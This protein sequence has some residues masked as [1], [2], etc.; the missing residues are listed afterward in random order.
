MAGKLRVTDAQV[1]GVNEIYKTA[2]AQADIE[3]AELKE[4]QNRIAAA[5]E[6][7]GRVQAFRFV[8]K[9]MTVCVLVQIAQIKE[10]KT[11]RDLPKIGTWEDFC[12]YIG[13]SRQHIEDQLKNLAAFGED[14]LQTVSGFGVGYR[15]M[16][17]LRQLTHDG[18]IVIDAEAVEIGGERVPL[19]PEHK[20]DLQALIERVIDEKD[21]ALNE[22]QAT[23]KAKDRR[24]EDKEKEIQKLHKELT[25]LEDKAAAG[26]MTAEEDSFLQKMKNLRMGF[27]GYM[28]K[29]DPDA[30]MSG[31]TEITPRIRAALISNLQYMRMQALAAYDTAVM[32]YGNPTINPEVAT[33]CEAFEQEY[34]AWT[35]QQQTSEA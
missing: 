25:K 26:K 29:A 28:L 4:K 23:L 32:T 22:A 7:I 18:T 33:E 14:F 34:E 5:H 11:Y 9:T 3:I 15:E 8:E 31:L 10:M 30:A 13:F 17:K 16:R 19:A 24:L 20:E 1:E 27:D 35:K 2:R 21:K 12:N 6:V